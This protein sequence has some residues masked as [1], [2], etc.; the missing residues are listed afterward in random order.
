MQY[1]YAYHGQQNK[2]EFNFKSGYGL[3]EKKKR[4]QIAINSHVIIIQKPE[5]DD[6]FRLCGI[7]RVTERYDDKKSTHPYRLKLEDVSKLSEYIELSI[8]NLNQILPN[9][10]GGS[11]GWTNFH[12]HFCARGLSFQKHLEEDVAE[13]LISQL[14]KHSIHHEERID[15]F[16]YS[17]EKSLKQDP[18]KRRERLKSSPKKPEKRTVSTIIYD[19][20]PDVVAEVLYMAKGKCS[21]CD[22]PAPFKRKKDGSP[23]LEV[24]HKVPL[25]QGDD[26]TTDNA[27]ALCPNCHREA[28]FG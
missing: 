10:D 15:F 14:K 6:A 18:E 13:I 2:N 25:A 21:K 20:N 24:H 3:T 16:Q 22:K 27:I 17:V 7:F 5:G 28:H 26:D 11:K 9:I 8:D 12:K 19:R 4:D 1:Y 23:Y